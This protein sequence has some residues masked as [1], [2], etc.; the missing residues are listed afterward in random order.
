[1]SECVFVSVSVCLI[2]W[3]SGVSVDAWKCFFFLRAH[4]VSRFC[5]SFFWF[6]L[7][8]KKKREKGR[9]QSFPTKSSGSGESLC[10]ER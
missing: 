3:S 9:G 6:Q 2:D 5:F 4:Y 10:F 8:K 7:K 1:M